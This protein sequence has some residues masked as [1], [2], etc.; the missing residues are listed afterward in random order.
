MWNIYTK[1]L[2][3]VL[4]L[5]TR[6][7]SLLGFLSF[8]APWLRGTPR[9]LEKTRGFRRGRACEAA[10]RSNPWLRG[11]FEAT[12]R[13][14]ASFSRPLY[15]RKHRSRVLSRPLGVP[16]RPLG[17][18]KHCFLGENTEKTRENAA[19]EGLRGHCVPE[20]AARALLGVAKVLEITVRSSL[21]VLSAHRSKSQTKAL[22]E[23][24]SLCLSTR[25]HFTRLQ[26][27]SVHVY[28][29]E[30]TSIYIYIYIY[31]LY[32]SRNLATR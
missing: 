1:V 18:R 24:T 27:C 6:F 5:R 13:S 4:G 23:V 2:L 20:I 19:R 9:K 32:A 3:R 29:R 15:A 26:H 10:V 12:V 8:V 14:K 21:G 25:L 7:P 30:H 17:A 28:A 16:P 31:I 11:A 22:F